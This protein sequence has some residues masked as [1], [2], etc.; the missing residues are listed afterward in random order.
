MPTRHCLQPLTTALRLRHAFKATLPAVGLGMAFTL[1]AQAQTQEWQ[2]DIPAGPLGRSIQELSHQ[3][4]LQILFNPEE[5]N[6]LRAHAVKGRYPLEE[7]LQI[8]LQGTGVR[9]S[10]QDNA[11]YFSGARSGA[12]ADQINLE[13]SLVS[14]KFTESAWG[15]VQGYVAKRSATGTKTDTSIL[16]TPQTINVVTQDEMTARGALSVTQALRYTPGIQVEGFSARVKAFDEPTSRGFSPTPMYLDGLHLPYGGGSTGGALQVDPY[17]LERVEVLKGPASVLYGQNQPGGIVN[18]VSKRPGVEPIHQVV[19]GTGSYDRRYGAFDFGGKLD[20]QGTFL[21]RLTGLANDSNSE[22]DYAEQKRMLLAPSFTWNIND[23]TSLTFYGQYQKDND[24]PEPQGLPAVG[25][26]FKNPNGKLDR[27]TF[28]GEPGLN[29][30]DREQYVFGYELT[31]QIDDVWSLRQNARYAYVDDRFAAVL[32]G[33]SFIANPATGVNNQRYT[34]RYAIDWKQT[35]KVFGIDNSAQ[36]VFNTGDVNHTVLLG[37]DYYHFNSKFLGRYDRNPPGID[38]YDPHYG[39]PLDFSQAA[40]NPW[41]DTITQTGVYVQDQLKW[42]RWFLTLGGR[43]DWAKIDYD[44]PLYVKPSTTRDQQF[45]GRAG[46]GYLFDNGITPYFSYSESFQPVAGT[47]NVDGKTFEPSTGKQYEV[48][49]KYQPPGSDSFI[50]L[51]AYQIDKKN[52]LTSDPANPGFN[53][54]AGAMRSVGFELEGKA[55]LTDN[56][57]LIAS[58]SRVDAEFTKDNDGLKGRHPVGVSPLTASAW[59]DYQMPADTALVGLGFGVGVR[60]V[61]S[62]PGTSYAWSEFNVPSFNVYDGMISYDLERSPLHIKGVK[63]QANVENLDNKLYVTRCS[64]MFE[65]TYGQG[66]TVTANLTYDW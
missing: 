62:S 1:A 36:A 41:D 27:N 35:N 45:S 14:G 43:F 12:D 29:A 59:V 32:H 11:I 22:V 63:V 55:A 13:P 49:I 37:L 30:Y 38:L 26:V 40:A 46:F 66:R 7:T 9:Y 54:Q 52:V 25:T 48:G 51:S 56:L 60:Y 50:Q 57:N 31:H 8:M 2:L 16:E 3:T 23:D 20:E 10:V 53:N 39:Q 17:L 19:L 44:H 4:G 34:D 28:I 61:R 18:M 6:G 5:I 64:G 15:P 33:Y 47:A 58:V 42:N 24:V 65:C 21:Y